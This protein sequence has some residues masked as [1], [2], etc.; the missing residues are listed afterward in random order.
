M[1]SGLS[2]VEELEVVLFEIVSDIEINQKEQIKKNF[3]P[4]YRHYTLGYFF[5]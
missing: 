1:T 3:P 2:F 4:R 5:Q